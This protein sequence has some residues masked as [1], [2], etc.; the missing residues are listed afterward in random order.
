MKLRVQTGCRRAAAPQRHL[1]VVLARHIA[2]AHGVAAG[3]A[4]AFDAGLQRGVGVQ[5]GHALVAGAAHV[6]P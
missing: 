6:G 4:Q 3:D 5:L 2:Q 1:G